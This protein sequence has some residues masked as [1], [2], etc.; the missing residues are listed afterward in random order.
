ME[1]RSGGGGGPATPSGTDREDRPAGTASRRS[2]FAV[3]GVPPDASAAQVKHAYRSLCARYHPDVM[4]RVEEP[5]VDPQGA[6]AIADDVAPFL[7]IQEA[8]LT[9]Q[10]R[11][12]RAAWEKAERDKENPS[13]NGW[14]HA[15]QH[16]CA[17]GAP[18]PEAARRRQGALVSGTWLPS[19]AGALARNRDYV[20]LGLSGFV[21][22]LLLIP[23]GAGRDGNATVTAIPSVTP[24]TEPP[25]APRHQRQAGSKA[26]PPQVSIAP[27][28][29]ETGQPSPNVQPSPIALP[30][31]IAQSSKRTETGGR[32]DEAADFPESIRNGA[33]ARYPA[34]TGNAPSLDR[35]NTARDNDPPSIRQARILDE[36]LADESLPHRLSSPAGPS[37]SP[38]EQNRWQGRWVAT[39][40]AARGADLY[41]GWLDI[42]ERARFRWRSLGTGASG[43]TKTFEIELPSG[44]QPMGESVRLR[45][46]GGDSYPVGMLEGRGAAGEWLSWL[47]GSA[48]PAHACQQWQLFADEAPKDLAG[49]WV[50]SPGAKG[51]EGGVVPEYVEL[52]MARNGV[53]HEGHFSGSYRVPV[54]SMASNLRFRFI[55]T[56][57]GSGWRPWV[58]PGGSSGKVLLANVGRSRLAVLWKRTSISSGRP[59]LT[60]GFALLRRME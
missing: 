39:C 13:G 5:P 46:P 6:R 1:R 56:S 3:L 47:P 52:R 37:P 42:R 25:I 12:A 44:G 49:L 29:A 20:W 51:P 24:A 7:E 59:Q 45:L 8:F 16:F 15:T 31:P 34:A 36:S 38:F 23:F 14:P 28:S 26:P 11:W 53:G 48:S 33:A 21:L 43:G 58:D 54:A 19:L 30:S 35:L 40:V 50:L 18:P 32:F 57:A 10:D 2:P 4:H 17:L 55:T 60:A 27:E 41:L 9:L 22:A